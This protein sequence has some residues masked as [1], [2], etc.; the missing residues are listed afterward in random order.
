MDRLRLAGRH[1]RRDGNAA[2]DGAALTY[3][4]RYALFISVGI[5]GEDDLDASDLLAPGP[6]S[7]PE[8]A[9]PPGKGQRLNGPGTIASARSGDHRKEGMNPRSVPGPGASS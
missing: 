8:R 3:A 2:P 6:R 9:E 5:A 7:V 4:R 1:Y